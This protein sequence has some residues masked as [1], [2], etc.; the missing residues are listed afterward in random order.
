MSD[1]QGFW[2]MERGRGM[3]EG[4]GGGG[5]GKGGCYGIH[6]ILSNAHYHILITIVH[7]NF[8]RQ[9]LVFSYSI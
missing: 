5:R 3:G 6:N 2:G 9:P 1:R 7:N 8:H 4:E